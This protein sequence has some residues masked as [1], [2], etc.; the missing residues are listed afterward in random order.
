M[1]AVISQILLFLG[2][3]ALLG[4]LVGY[5]VHRAR[6]TEQITLLEREQRMRIETRDQELQA[7]RREVETRRAATEKLQ[8]RVDAAEVKR[9][10]H[11]GTLAERDARIRDLRAELAASQAGA[12]K[13][14]GA[15]RGRLR[16]AEDERKA[17][18]KAAADLE[19]ALAKARAAFEVKDKE[20]AELRARLA[21][22]DAAQKDLRAQAARLRD[23]ERHRVEAKGLGR[24]LSD[25][26]ARMEE[27]ESRFQA[28]LDA[29]AA[30]VEKLQRRILELEGPD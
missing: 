5:F 11:E 10:G 1:L 20:N 29:K 26:D 14:L 9:L 15:L 25:R 12:E 19:A 23:L 27:L 24:E 2:L 13:E 17:R 21:E 28:A 3:A 16:E 4:F 22:S 6:S 18:G 8:G 7:L 30:E